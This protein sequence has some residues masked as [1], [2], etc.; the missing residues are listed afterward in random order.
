MTILMNQSDGYRVDDDETFEA[1]RFE[2]FSYSRNGECPVRSHASRTRGRMRSRATAAYI[3][4][5]R[6]FNGAHRRGRY[7]HTSPSY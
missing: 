7:T 4:K 2:R 3:R 1:E 6:A 5:I